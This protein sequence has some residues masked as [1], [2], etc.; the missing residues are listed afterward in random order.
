MD[1]N[2]CKLSTQCVNVGFKLEK[3]RNEEGEGLSVRLERYMVGL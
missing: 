2:G 1:G 3:E